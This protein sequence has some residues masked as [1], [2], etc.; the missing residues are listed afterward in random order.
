MAMEHFD[1]KIVPTF[2]INPHSPIAGTAS[3]VNACDLH[4]SN[5]LSPSKIL[6]GAFMPIAGP[7]YLGVPAGVSSPVFGSLHSTPKGR[8]QTYADKQL[9]LKRLDEKSL[10]K[11][12]ESL[13]AVENSILDSF[14][15]SHRVLENTIKRQ[16]RLI[17]KMRKVS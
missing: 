15:N 9:L 11:S 2:K 13:N 12:T 17:K 14:T 5:S 10:N 16:N 4:G 7:S 6:S 3:M 8:F 1:E